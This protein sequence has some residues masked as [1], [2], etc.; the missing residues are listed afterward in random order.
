MNK[1]P[2]KSV[3]GE[4]INLVDYYAALF[5]GDNQYYRIK[6]YHRTSKSQ[7]HICFID[8]GNTANINIEK[9]YELPNDPIM[10]TAPIAFECVLIEVQPA[11]DINRRGIWSEHVNELFDEK[12]HNAILHGK[13][14]KYKFTVFL[15]NWIFLFQLSQNSS[16]HIMTSDKAPVTPT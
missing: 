1:R 15:Y 2:L 8:Y 13:V 3:N 5:T 7:A 10:K 12:T 6:I 16:N 14:R 9:L 11:W 4:K